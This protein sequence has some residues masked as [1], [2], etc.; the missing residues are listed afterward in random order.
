MTAD[1]EDARRAALLR[2]LD[3]VRAVVIATENCSRTERGA[4]GMTIDAQLRRTVI[5]RVPAMPV[6]ELIEA[7]FE[8]EGTAGLAAARK[9]RE[10]E[11][12]G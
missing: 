4:G 2:L 7:L 5:N 12:G 10:R 11:K 6:E 9:E 8:Y 3:A 1:R